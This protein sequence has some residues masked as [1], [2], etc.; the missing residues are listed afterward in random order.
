MT[1]LLAGKLH[2]PLGVAE[3]IIDL[4]RL[5]AV[6]IRVQVRPR[7]LVLW[8]H[9][10]EAVLRS[11]GVRNEDS[12]VQVLLAFRIELAELLPGLL[13]NVLLVCRTRHLWS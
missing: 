5:D 11:E 3:H 4:A 9:G 6:D 2:L 1:H 13:S 7:V 8:E 12:L 10:L